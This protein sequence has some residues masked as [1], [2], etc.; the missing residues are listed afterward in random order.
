MATLLSA[1]FVAV[2]YLRNARNYFST[3]N[4]QIDGDTVDVNV[5]P[6]PWSAGPSSPSRLT[7]SR[8]SA[9]RSRGLSIATQ[10]AA[11][12]QGEMAWRT[13]LF[14]LDGSAAFSL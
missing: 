10:S 11:V 2:S 6:P 3:D 8:G 14:E 7:R 4:V 5:L 1:V 9:H 12:H 13:K